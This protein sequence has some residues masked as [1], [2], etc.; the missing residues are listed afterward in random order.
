M[1]KRIPYL[2][3]VG[4]R[5]YDDRKRDRREIWDT[6]TLTQMIT[7]GKTEIPLQERDAEERLRLLQAD[8]DD[9]DMDP[10]RFCYRLGERN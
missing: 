8:M 2:R 9:R 5:K 1:K 10:E 6:R 3:C 4:F 7:S